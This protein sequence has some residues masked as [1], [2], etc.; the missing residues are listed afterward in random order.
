MAAV[1]G[2]LDLEGLAV[3]GL[4]VQHD[5]ADRLGAGPEVD[6]QPLRVGERAGPAGAG[7]AVDRGRGRDA[8]VLGGGGGGRAALGGVRRP[9]GCVLLVDRRV[10]LTRDDEC[11]GQQEA[12]G[13]ARA[14]ER[15][16]SAG[17]RREGAGERVLKD[18]GETNQTVN[19]AGERAL[20]ERV[21]PLRWLSRERSLSAVPELRR[22]CSVTVRGS[23][24]SGGRSRRVGKA[25][26]RRAD[27]AGTRPPPRRRGPWPRAWRTGGMEVG[28]HRR[29]GDEQ[30]GGDLAVGGAAGDQAPGFE[31]ARAQSFWCSGVSGRWVSAWATVGESTPL[32]AGRCFDGTAGSV[33]RGVLEQ[34]A[35]RA[36]VDRRVDPRCRRRR[37]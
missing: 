31:F 3:R 22:E 18:M 35:G 29:L 24:V 15:R 5:L 26:S 13:R 9:A 34:V 20:S 12:C 21:A 25:G 27:R 4:P 11:G 23:A 30:A 28:L 36:L 32:A 8:A 17:D 14:R 37:W 2:G 1:G 19:R 33:A 6:L 7:V 16:R 10:G